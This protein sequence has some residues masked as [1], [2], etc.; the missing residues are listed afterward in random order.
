[1]Y[2][3]IFQFFNHRLAELGIEGRGQGTSSSCKILP[4]KGSV[5]SALRKLCVVIINV[6]WL[7]CCQKITHATTMA[8]TESTD[9]T[10]VPD[11]P[12]SQ[13]S[14]AVTSKTPAEV[15]ADSG[16]R[17]QDGFGCLNYRPACLQFLASARW[18]LVFVCISVFCETMSSK[19][20]LAVVI[21]TLER[22]FGLSSSQSAW[23]VVSYEIAGV[24]ALLIIGYL[25]STLRRPVWIGA[26]LLMI[27][28]GLGIFTIPHFAAP[29]YRF[30]ESSDSSNLCVE[31]ASNVLSNA[32]SSTYDRY[33]L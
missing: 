9:I 29:P 21:S 26:G 24:P 6:W 10:T 32:S 19:G 25:G 22:R 17:F 7:F 3:K 1:M 11:I 15:E 8:N 13:P 4:S 20:L 18:F 5:N 30:A 23:I 31:T 12:Q 16:G 2:P 27:G 33:A 14:I 28:I